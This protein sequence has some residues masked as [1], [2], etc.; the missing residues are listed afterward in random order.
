LAFLTGDWAQARSDF[1]RA[2][3]AAR[4]SMG[5]SQASLILMFILRVAEGHAEVESAEV[6]ERI[7]R[8]VKAHHY[9]PACEVR[10]ALAERDMLAGRFASARDRLLPLLE[11][12]RDE[13]DED[14]LIHLLI[15]LAWA[16]L[17]VGEVLQAEEHVDEIRSRIETTGWHLWLPDVLRVEAL[18]RITQQRWTEAEVAL[19]EALKTARAM[20]YPYAEAKV[21]WAY[22]QL[23]ARRGHPQAAR[24]RF[25]AALAICDQ[26]GEGLYRSDIERVLR[27]FDSAD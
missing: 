27:R 23:E 10:S 21:L 15:H 25:S 3:E 8:A 20:P 11:D 7:A 24:E 1:A 14:A 2:D 5:R 19:E 4:K 17:G 12:Y 13:M 9:D 6:L 18:I 22:G 26:L 16:R